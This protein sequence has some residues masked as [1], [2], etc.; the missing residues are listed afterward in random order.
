MRYE[1][2]VQSAEPAFASR[3]PISGAY[4]AM[5]YRNIISTGLIQYEYILA[6]YPVG[7]GQACLY[8]SSEQNLGRGGRSH[9][10]GLFNDIG[11]LNV[12]SDDRWADQDTFFLAALELA[13]KEVQPSSGP[14][15]PPPP[16][17]RPGPPPPQQ[18]TRPPGP[19]PP[20]PTPSDVASHVAVGRTPEADDASKFRR[21]QA[22]NADGRREDALV[23]FDEVR[24]EGERL[25]NTEATAGSLYEIGRIRYDQGRL[26]AAEPS[27]EKALELSVQVDN[28]LRAGACCELLAMV[29]LSRGDDDTARAITR[30]GCEMLGSRGEWDHVARLIESLGRGVNESIPVLAQAVWLG[31][32]TDVSDQNKATAAARLVTQLGRGSKLSYALAFYA[33]SLSLQE[34]RRDPQ[35]EA[36][37]G[38]AAM[39]AVDIVADPSQELSAK[40]DE[41]ALRSPDASAL[42][43]TMMEALIEHIGDRWLFDQSPLR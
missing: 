13:Q 30:R 15:G 34:G 22:M 43:P 9:V 18:P 12:G 29:A 40:L 28:V 35:A 25:G 2:R 37:I 39:A 11:H 20:P 6:V 19:P 41:V 21:A 38:G 36:I 42:L 14:P 10:L 24:V 32:V 7:S 16:T 5:L 3:Q 26:D 27:L 23:L 31:L 4:E 8:V 1:P 17:G 33:L